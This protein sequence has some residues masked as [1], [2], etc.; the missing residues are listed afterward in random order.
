M[1]LKKREGH[2]K[3]R[4]S[5]SALPKH[6]AILQYLCELLLSNAGLPRLPKHTRN[7]RAGYVQKSGPARFAEAFKD[8]RLCV[9]VVIG[10][11]VE[12]VHFDENSFAALVGSEKLLAEDALV[13]IRSNDLVGP[14][15][16]RPTQEDQKVCVRHGELEKVPPK[17]TRIHP[18]Y[19]SDEPTI[20]A[21]L[22]KPPQH[23]QFLLLFT[24]FSLLQSQQQRA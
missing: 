6:L 5:H 4:D 8:A 17:T 2:D 15:R 24:I 9:D 12:E 16:S 18:N 10:H 14:F 19:Q 7:S 3:G 13:E 1:G 20:A 22:L 23:Q 11:T 21:T